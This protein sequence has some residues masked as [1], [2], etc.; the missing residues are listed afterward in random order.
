[1]RLTHFFSSFE[2]TQDSALSATRGFFHGENVSARPDT[3]SHRLLVVTVV[4]NN[5]LSAERE[6]Q[7]LLSHQYSP[8]DFRAS[9]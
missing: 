6:Y 1:V 3:L 9:N 7:S 4:A 2:E 8:R 5:A